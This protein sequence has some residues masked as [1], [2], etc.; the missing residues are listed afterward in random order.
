MKT[1]NANQKSKRKNLS[2]RFTRRNLSFKPTPKPA[3]MVR[4]AAR[5]FRGYGFHHQQHGL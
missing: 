4:F 1:K 5:F 3:H 2:Q